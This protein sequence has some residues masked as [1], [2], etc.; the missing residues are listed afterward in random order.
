MLNYLKKTLEILKTDGV[1]ET[2]RRTGTHLSRWITG[3]ANEKVFTDVLFIN[4]FE[5]PASRQ[6]LYRI[7]N[8][9]E[10]L[11]AYNISTA[12][13]FFAELDLEWV[14]YAHI[15][16]FVGCL[17][18]EELKIF[19]EF[20]KS[21]NKKVLIDS[22][23]PDF[24]MRKMAAICD[25]VITSSEQLTLKLRDFVPEVF[26]NRNCVSEK[27]L[28]LAKEAARERKVGEIHFGYFCDNGTWD[29]FSA[30]IPAVTSILQKNKH[31]RLFLFGTDGLPKKLKAFSHRIVLRPL[32]LWYEIPKAMSGL[33]ILLL[34]AGRPDCS[35]SILE[36]RWL[37]AALSKVVIVADGNGTHEYSEMLT[38]GETGFLCENETAWEQKLENLLKNEELRKRI[39]AKAC[40]Y[41]SETFGTIAAGRDFA[42]FIREKI[43]NTIAFCLQSTALSGG[44]IIALKHACLLQRQGYAV[45]FIA[46]NASQDW[47]KYED[48]RFPVLE[49]EQILWL[50]HFEKMTA[51]FWSTVS[52]VEKYPYVCK[53]LYLVQGKETDFYPAGKYER[54]GANRT[55]NLD[56]GFKYI[57][58]SKWSQYWLQEQFGK[59]AAYAPNG[60]D[61]QLF[62]PTERDY[63]GKIRILIEGDSESE[64]KRI[65]ESFTITNRLDLEKFE[66]WYMSY[67]GQPK[68]WY[69]VDK[70]IHNIPHE[71]VAD[72][73]RNCH[74]LLKSSILECFP[75]PPLEMMATGGAVI[76]VPNDGNAQYAIDGENCLI[77]PTGEIDRAYQLLWKIVEDAEL[78][79]HLRINGI[80][81]AQK[82][83]WK[84]IEPQILALY[85]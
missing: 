4:G 75:L 3:K 21:L 28:Q 78:R 71:K 60:I 55:Y 10:Q 12:E 19:A 62:Y 85:E 31:V 27:M 24:D 39:A 38:D 53:R 49:A 79:K 65:D 7:R 13:I 32:P 41:V 1:G 29:D 25:A 6:V 80:R 50:S 43:S 66:I 64:F 17:C 20:A 26:I 14:K 58:I 45:T 63:S 33:D 68:S 51:T 5:D 9:Q 42:A 46:N 69:R 18:T 16:I 15:F 11:E 59:Y 73:Y 8:Q 67:H 54:I 81:T 82:Y 34:P 83:D 37:E 52:F 2:M 22:C 40:E 74:I 48:K 23:S 76:M 70:F 36:A 44:V 77:Y 56:G 61:S 84:H 57:T 30:A 35:N 72:V 47:M